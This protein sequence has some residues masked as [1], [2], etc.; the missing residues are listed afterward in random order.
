MKN[1]N[2]IT[3][4][5]STHKRA[6]LGTLATGLLLS[7]VPVF[8]HQNSD[9]NNDTIADI[10]SHPHIHELIDPRWARRNLIDTDQFNF[11][12]KNDDANWAIYETG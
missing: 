10:S 5:L 12:E 6:L 2:K 4:N 1:I 3:T 8:A 9:V 11:D 7:S